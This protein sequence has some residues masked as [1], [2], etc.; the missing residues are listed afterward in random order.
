MST[1]AAVAWVMTLRLGRDRLGVRKP[2][3]AL[4]RSPSFWFTWYKKAPACS[5]PL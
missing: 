3:A 4:Q 2:F 5:A 1:F